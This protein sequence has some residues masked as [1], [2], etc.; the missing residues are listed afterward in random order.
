MIDIVKKQNNSWKMHSEIYTKAEKKY[1]EKKRIIWENSV[2]LNAKHVRRINYSKR[3]RR[4]KKL[5]IIPAKHKRELFFVTM[6]ATVLKKM[7]YE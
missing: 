1:E 3:K 4:K 5:K 2:M 6:W 7:Y